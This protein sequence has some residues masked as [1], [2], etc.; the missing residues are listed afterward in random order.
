MIFAFVYVS[1]VV[2]R[3]KF[4]REHEHEAMVNLSSTANIY[5]SF[6][7]LFNRIALVAAE[8]FLFFP[9]AA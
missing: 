5:V 7:F 6:F 8:Q 3:R 2:R 9:S 1:F 4:T